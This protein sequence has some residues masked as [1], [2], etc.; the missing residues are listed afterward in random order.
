MQQFSSLNQQSQDQISSGSY[1]GEVA[2]AGSE[3]GRE[4]P[5]LSAADGSQ[6]HSVLTQ[7]SAFRIIISSREV[8]QKAWPGV[9]FTKRTGDFGQINFKQG[10]AGIISREPVSPIL[11]PSKRCPK[12]Y[13]V[14]QPDGPT[15]MARE[16]NNGTYQRE[17]QPSK[18]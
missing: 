6:I 17:K 1:R 9:L 13:P 4:E 18:T 11:P 14:L 5:L 15:C 2:G 16:P 3:E 10:Q 8:F 7:K 12:C